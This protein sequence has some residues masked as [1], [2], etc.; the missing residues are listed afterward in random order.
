MISRL[1]NIAAVKFDIHELLE[2]RTQI[3]KGDI[4]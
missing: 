1:Q 3:S 2:R 4:V